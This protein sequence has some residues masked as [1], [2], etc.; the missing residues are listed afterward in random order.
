MA[1]I[2]KTNCPN[3][4]NIVLLVSE[5]LVL[6]QNCVIFN[7]IQFYSNFIISILAIGFRSLTS[8]LASAHMHFIKFVHRPHK[9]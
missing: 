7:A 2:A 5:H 6:L 4:K 8:T 3:Y 9:T 1:N